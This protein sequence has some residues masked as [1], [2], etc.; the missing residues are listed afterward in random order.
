[1]AEVVI[2]LRVM[3]KDP[4]VDLDALSNWCKEKIETFGGKV[5]KIEKTPIAFGITALN[6]TFLADESKGGTDKLEE[7][8]RKNENVASAEVVDVRRAFG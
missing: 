5:H 1:M 8:L 2:I 7:E 3:P 6:F 4:N